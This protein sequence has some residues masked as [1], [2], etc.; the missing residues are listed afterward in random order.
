M[1][2]VLAS[3]GILI[4]KFVKTDCLAMNLVLLMVTIMEKIGTMVGFQMGLKLE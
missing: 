3:Y 1:S 2:C 4:S